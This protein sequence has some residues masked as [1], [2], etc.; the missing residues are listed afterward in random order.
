[1]HGYKRFVFLAFAFV[2]SVMVHSRTASA[3]Q[4]VTCEFLAADE[5]GNIVQQQTAMFLSGEMDKCK[6][7]WVP[8]GV[9]FCN[10]HPLPA[11]WQIKWAG[12]AMPL[13]QKQCPAPGQPQKYPCGFNVTDVFGQVTY[14]NNGETATEAECL[15]AWNTAIANTCASQPGSTHN[16]FFDWNNRLIRTAKCTPPPPAQTSIVKPCAQAQEYAKYSRCWGWHI[17]HTYDLG[18][19][20]AIKTVKGTV[21]AG[22]SEAKGAAYS[23]QLRIS[24]DGTNWT[25]VGTISATGATTKSFGPVNVNQSA[26]YVQIF[27][28]NS[29]YV[30]NSEI[31]V[32]Y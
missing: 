8:S 10:A 13:V 30:D 6:N 15:A 22:P 7:K 32:T 2:L 18:K 14:Q 23:W 5:N 20:Y 4:Q 27:T 11:A 21:Y 28:N 29:G 1:M 17:A 19:S 16:T 31:T 26:R 9:A 3:G 24:T 25:S 12:T